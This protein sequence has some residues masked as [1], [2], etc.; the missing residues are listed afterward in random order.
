MIK[1]QEI[2][3]QDDETLC[4][5][6]MA[7][8]DQWHTPRPAV[9][10]AHDW[11]GRGLQICNIAKYMA[12]LGFVGFAL[13]MYGQ[14]QLGFD[15]AARQALI[16]PFKEDR[17]LL[18][19]RITSAFQTLQNLNLVNAHL[20]AAMGFC[21][22]GM[23][24]LDLARSHAV[25][26]S[27]ISIHGILTPPPFNDSLA[28]NTKILILHGYQD[29]LVP[30]QQ[31]RAFAKEMADRKVDYQIQQFGLAK[32]GF[33]NPLVC[34]K[35]LDFYYDAGSSRRAWDAAYYF[36][37]SNGFDSNNLSTF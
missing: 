22:G 4:H 27:V 32:H 11:H 36:L 18:L 14:A 23:C 6:F 20:I 25:L 3:Y 7:Y 13:D 5:G 24:V 21:F 10:L 9:L 1:T 2:P 30:P 17:R 19:K 33:S 8:D 37:V 15:T 12:K 26:Q 34:D 29:C 16:R 35:A 28:L 31:V